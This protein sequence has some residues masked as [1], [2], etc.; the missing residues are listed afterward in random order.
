MFSHFVLRT[1]APPPL[2]CGSH[3]WVNAELPVLLGGPCPFVP[4]ASHAVNGALKHPKWGQKWRVTWGNISSEKCAM[5]C[6][7]WPILLKQL[8]NVAQN[9]NCL[10]WEWDGQLFAILRHQISSLRRGKNTSIVM[11]FPLNNAL[12]LLFCKSKCSKQCSTTVRYLYFC[13]VH[14]S[15]LLV[16]EKQVEKSVFEQQRPQMTKPRLKHPCGGRKG[17]NFP[18]S[19]GHPLTRK[20]I[21]WHPHPRGVK[22]LQTEQ[23][24]GERRRQWMGKIHCLQHR[25][26]SI[27]GECPLGGGGGGVQLKIESVTF[28]N[29]L[30]HSPPRLRPMGQ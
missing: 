8:G 30:C 13:S 28:K 7:Q 14:I 17:G 22:G 3:L 26:L 19:K 11:F 5:S 15:T 4:R 12:F 6:S 27:C 21:V 29:S 10:L 1:K 18:P 23:K 9:V 16:N 24:K 25:S 20:E 2:G